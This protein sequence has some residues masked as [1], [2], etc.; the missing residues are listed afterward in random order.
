MS[1]S[2]GGKTAKADPV[3]QA[4]IRLESAVERLAQVLS[5]ALAQRDAP[6]AAGA[7]E[8]VSR[9]EVAALADRLDATLA[10]LRGALAEELRR[11][12]PGGQEEA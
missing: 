6:E 3:T 10:R 11:A 4:T 2:G 9:A 12:S 1:D 5:A 7:E 8:V